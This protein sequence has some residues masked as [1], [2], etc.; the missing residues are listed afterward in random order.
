MCRTVC[1]V[2][3][4]VCMGTCVPMYVRICTYVHLPQTM[5]IYV[6]VCMYMMCVCVIA[7]SQVQG[8]LDGQERRVGHM[9][10]M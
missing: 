10:C 6:T 8:G 4:S 3:S 9:T 7:G 5:C 1:E 2:P